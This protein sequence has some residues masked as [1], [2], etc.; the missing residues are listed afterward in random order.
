MSTTQIYEAILKIVR[1]VL[2]PDAA[3][4]LLDI[5]AGEGRLIAA[6]KAEFPNVKAQ[7][8]DYHI[9]RF[10]YKDVPI[11]EIDLNCEVLPFE[12]ASFDLVSCA[13]NSI[14]KKDDVL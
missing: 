5:G 2:K 11:Q 8:C 6:L 3:F 10:P 4:A 9:E 13:F 14:N 7:G 1:T 12:E